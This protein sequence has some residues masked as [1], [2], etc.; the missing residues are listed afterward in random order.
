MDIRKQ[1]QYWIKGG[2]EDLDAACSLLEKK[3]FRHALFFA[4]LALE[5]VIKARVTEVTKDVPPRIHDLLRLSD[6]AKI[7]LSK[8]QKEFLARFQKY[9]IEGRYPDVN[10]PSPTIQETEIAIEDVREFIQWLRN[11]L[12]L[13]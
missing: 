13:Q 12:N 2:E 10:P 8:K 1:I 5:K 11:R 6:M 3:H 9:S 4:H 7:S